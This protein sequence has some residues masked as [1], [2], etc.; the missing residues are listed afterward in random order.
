M[1]LLFGTAGIPLSSRLNTT[2]TGIERLRELGLDCLEVQFVQ[3][4]KMGER[5]ALMVRE[6][7]E[8]ERVRLSVHAPYFINLNAHEEDKR[9]AS[10]ARLL[11]AARIGK[12]CGARNIVFH[13]AF[14]L[15]DPPEQVYLR[16]KAVLERLVRQL[17]REGNQTI[18]RPEV[19]GKYSQFGSIEEVLSLSAEIEG[20][21]PALDLSHWHARCEGACNSYPEFLALLRQ[22]ESR[23]GRGA[24]EDLHLHLSGIEYTKAGERKHL[25]LR[26]SDFRYLELLR[27]LKEVGAGGIAICESPNLEED[28]LVLQQAYGSL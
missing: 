16:V 8:R 24:V 3:G 22:V 7:A 1:A 15:G 6:A 4:V 14:Y 18:L 26:E 21:A 19:T 9:A 27:A 28:A 5:A 25:V 10:E 17:R 23:L 2:Q 13:A 20:V 12:L 11:Q